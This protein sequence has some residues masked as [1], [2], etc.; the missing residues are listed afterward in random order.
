MREMLA[1]MSEDQTREIRGGDRRSKSPRATLKPTPAALGITKRG[2]RGS[3]TAGESAAEDYCCGEGRDE[4]PAGGEAGGASERDRN[5]GC[6]HADRTVPHHYADPPRKY[7]DQL[8]AE[9]G[10]TRFHYPAISRE[11]SNGSR[12]RGLH[13]TRPAH[14]HSTGTCAEH[15]GVIPIHPMLM[16]I[17][18][19]LIGRIF[20]PRLPA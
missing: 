2:E 16:V 17:R 9:Y 15:P 3:A 12:A 5:S 14:C 18:C 13:T 20:F 6:R 7:G 8:T 11:R 10:A 4:D 1:T 19:S